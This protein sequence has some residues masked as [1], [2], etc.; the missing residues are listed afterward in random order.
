MRQFIGYLLILLGL[1]FLAMLFLRLWNIAPLSWDNV[2]R[3]FF[4]FLLVLFGAVLVLAVR[5]LFFQ[6][7]PVFQRLRQRRSRLD[8]PV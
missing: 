6:E 8:E 5:Y 1:A 7:P 4:T 3:V 2:V